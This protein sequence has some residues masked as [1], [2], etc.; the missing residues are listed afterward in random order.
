MLTAGLGGVDFTDGGT[1]DHFVFTFNWVAAVGSLDTR[2][3]VTDTEGGQVSRAHSFVDVANTTE[4]PVF[5]EDFGEDADTVFHDVDALEIVL[6]TEETPNID[7]ALESIQIVPEPGAW[8]L[9]AVGLSALGLCRWG[10][11]RHVEINA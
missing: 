9:L 8:A 1:N 2:I 10:R 6:N 7:F 3:T 11:R 5:F 4:F